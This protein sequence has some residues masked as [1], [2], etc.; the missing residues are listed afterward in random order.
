MVYITSEEFFKGMDTLFKVVGWIFSVFGI[1]GLILVIASYPKG[2]FSNDVLSF[3]SGF[4][5]SYMAVF[6]LFLLKFHNQIIVRPE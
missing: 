2:L 3:I 1:G 5:Y 6:G 4:I